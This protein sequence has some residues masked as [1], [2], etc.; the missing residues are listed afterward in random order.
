MISSLRTVWKNSSG[1]VI[2]IA[3]EVV[4]DEL[5]LVAGRDLFTAAFGVEHAAIDLDDLFEERN[6]ELKPRLGDNANRLTQTQ[7]QGLFP[8]MH[9]KHRHQRDDD[10]NGN[11]DHDADGSV[12]VH[13]V[14]PACPVPGSAALVVGAGCTMRRISSFSD[15]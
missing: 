15:R 1:L 13:G 3:R 2:L 5:F 4:D 12:L 8:L 14:A 7:H 9:R 6:P 11:C 10:D